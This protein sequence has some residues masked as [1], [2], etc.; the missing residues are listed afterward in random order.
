[1]RFSTSSVDLNV[2]VILSVLKSVQVKYDVIGYYSLQYIQPPVEICG[3]KLKRVKSAHG[4]V[5]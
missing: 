3:G 5:E 1:M 4:G 2:V